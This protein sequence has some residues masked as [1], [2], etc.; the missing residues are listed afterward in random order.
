MENSVKTYVFCVCTLTNL[1]V[2]VSGEPFTIF[3]DIHTF[4]TGSYRKRLAMFQINLKT[5]NFS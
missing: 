5:M 1:E 4:G 2:T 3:S